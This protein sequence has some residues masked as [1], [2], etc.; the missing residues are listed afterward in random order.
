M[1]PCISFDKA[2]ALKASSKNEA[3]VF[4]K[5]CLF[6]ADC[7]VS[8]SNQ[9]W[10][11]IIEKQLKCRLW[12]ASFSLIVFLIQYFGSKNGGHEL[13]TI[14]SFFRFHYFI[15]L[16]LF[17]LYHVEFPTFW[18]TLWPAVWHKAITIVF[19]NHCWIMH[20]SFSYHFDYFWK[21][22]SFLLHWPKSWFLSCTSWT[23]YVRTSP[24]T[25][26]MRAIEIIKKR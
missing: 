22:W 9:I 25:C 18:P 24:Q 19:S 12:K 14:I 17:G 13:E 20:F 6:L 10:L 2:K 3:K 7:D 1:S 5:I 15:G 23:V 11:E 26:L 21:L 16:G 4:R 8:F